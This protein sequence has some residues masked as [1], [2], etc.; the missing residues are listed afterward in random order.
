VRRGFVATRADDALARLG[1][2]GER[3]VARSDAD[4]EAVGARERRVEDGE[5]AFR[6][7]R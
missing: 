5:V 4:Q 3:R 2:R 7:A 1:E 6:P